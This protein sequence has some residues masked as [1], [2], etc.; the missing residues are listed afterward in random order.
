MVLHSVDVYISG[1][2]LQEKINLVVRDA[3]LEKS[4]YFSWWCDTKKGY[5]KHWKFISPTTESATN[6]NC[7]ND[8]QNIKSGYNVLTDITLEPLVSKLPVWLRISLTPN[9]CMRKTFF[10]LNLNK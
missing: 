4:F 3:V 7:H 10:D 1:E 8:N 9:L 2:V 6:Y 5:V